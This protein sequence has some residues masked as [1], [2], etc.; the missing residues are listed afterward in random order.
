MTYQVTL[1]AD[2][3]AE[4]AEKIAEL[5]TEWAHDLS[6]T[7]VD[8]PDT[9]TKTQAHP[10]LGTEDDQPELPL[11]ESAEAEGNEEP[12]AEEQPEPEQAPADEPDGE[13]AP[14]SVDQLREQVMQYAE[15][16]GNTKAKELL[17]EFGKVSQVPEEDR[18]RIYQAAGGEL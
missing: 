17:A 2:S 4:L 1:H 8:T 11:Q 6:G 12:A 16:N 10:N 9:P 18:N 14:V 3:R 13:P 5:A 15:K 7:T